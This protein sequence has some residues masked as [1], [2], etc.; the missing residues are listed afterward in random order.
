MLFH[1]YAHLLTFV[2]AVLATPTP[3]QLGFD[4]VV[5]LNADGSSSVMKDYEYS[6]LVARSHLRP[7]P[8]TDLSVARA[9][10]SGAKKLHR[11][12][13]DSNEV[14]VTSDTTFLNWDVPMSPV[15]SAQ[16][17]TASV[18]IASGYS[19]ANSVSVS[20]SETLTLLKDVLQASLSVSYTETWTTTE[21][22]TFQYTVPDGQFGLVVSQPSVRRVVGNYLSG[23]VDAQ[24][25]EAFTSDTYS[26]QAFGNLNWVQGV[27]RLCNSTTYPVPYCIGDGTHS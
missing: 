24:D 9:E 8:R 27:I 4:D 5:L 12:C 23:C 19:L 18:S 16:G 15:V 6:G 13:D 14:Q 2:G 10:T 11:R 7:A 22:Q 25:S 26:S 1:S 20:A 21:T 17:G 3:Q